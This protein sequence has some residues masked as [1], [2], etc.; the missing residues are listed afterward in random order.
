MPQPSE[1][2]L[3]VAKKVLAKIASYDPHFPQP[4]P[5][6]VMA[7]GEQ[8]TIANMTEQDMLD[9]VTKF[10]ETAVAGAKP[11]PASIIVLAN[12]SRIQ[13]VQGE[14]QQAR[15]EREDR[16]DAKLEGREYVRPLPE[17]GAQKITMAEWE[18]RHGTRFP[19]AALGLDIPDG[20]NPL[21]VACPWCRQPEG[22][23]CVVPGSDQVLSEGRSHDSRIA[24]SQGRCAASA[25]KHVIP[26]S[27]D[28]ERGGM[29]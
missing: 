3:G 2:A 16:R 21:K 14:S 15:E 6:M 19:R 22:Y 20:P 24:I 28:C 26:H 11:L 13:R 23:R 18:E 8:I 17:K 25:G 5:S 29:Q 1:R 7:W 27:D 10:Y 9:G 4:S 12:Q